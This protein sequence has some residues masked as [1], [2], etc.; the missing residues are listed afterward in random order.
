MLG[1]TLS[2]MV[3]VMGNGIGDTSS[4]PRRVSHSV[5][6]LEKSTNLSVLHR[7][8]FNGI[9]IFEVYLLLQRSP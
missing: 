9:S 4:N 3:I 1:S 6:A 5:T 8:V 7:F 2:V